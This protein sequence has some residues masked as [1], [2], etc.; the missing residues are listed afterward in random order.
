MSR[1]YKDRIKNWNYEAK[2]E[3]QKYSNRTR[4]S[5]GKELVVEYYKAADVED[6][7]SPNQIHKNSGKGD[8]WKWD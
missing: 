2:H 8:I 7:E 3:A 5:Y 6:V 4:R 1:S